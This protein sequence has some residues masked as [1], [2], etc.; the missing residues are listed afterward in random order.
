MGYYNVS[1]SR[2]PR[3]AGRHTLDVSDQEKIDKAADQAATQAA[4]IVRHWLENNLKDHLKQALKEIY[5]SLWR[6]LFTYLYKSNLVRL[7]AGLL[8]LA[9]AITLWVKSK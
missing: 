5:W 8:T 9:S 3:C 2:S 6:E 7:F 4:A 1:Q